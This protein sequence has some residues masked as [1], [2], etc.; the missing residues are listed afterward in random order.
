MRKIL[1]NTLLSRVLFLAISFALVM[2]VIACSIFK[3]AQEKEMKALSIES[4]IACINEV[5]TV[6]EPE[7]TIIESG[8]TEIEEVI[9]L[10]GATVD[11]YTIFA[12]DMEK[13]KA[14]DADT[15]AKYFGTSD[16]FTP[17][18]IADR[19]SVSTITFLDSIINDEGKD[20][21]GV[22]ICTLDYDLMNGDFDTILAEKKA[23]YEAAVADGKT[24]DTDY[25]EEAKKA[26]AY[27]LVE[28]K[29]EV[30]YTIYVIVDNGEVQVSESIKQA[31]TGGWYTGIGVELTKT[32]CIV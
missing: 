23:E 32:D 19:V 20:Q 10:S 22:H 14:A 6:A 12:E 28:G 25:N 1:D 30:C 8:D 21:V 3:D 29:Y 27:N 4:S 31:I 18:L 24:P 26:V 9:P 11:P 16:V 7:V 17:E 5:E 2:I 13:L 15:V